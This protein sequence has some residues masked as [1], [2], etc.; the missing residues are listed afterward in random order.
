MQGSEGFS[1]TDLHTHESQR[2]FFTIVGPPR[3]PL[4]RCGRLVALRTL[5]CMDIV[6]VDVPIENDARG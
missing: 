4:C 3:H 1:S 2:N 5:L 6:A